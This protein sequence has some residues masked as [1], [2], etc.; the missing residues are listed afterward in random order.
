[1]SAAEP[2]RPDTVDAFLKAFRASGLDPRAFCPAYGL[3][4]HTVG[5]TV[6]GQRLA[7]VDRDALGTQR[8]A[9]ALLAD[10]ALPVV[11]TRTDDDDARPPTPDAPTATAAPDLLAAL[12]RVVSS[13][14]RLSLG[15]DDDLQRH[16][17][18]DSLQ[19][20]E[21]GMALERVAGRGVSAATLQ[22]C[23]TLRALAR[24]LSGAAPSTRLAL[25]AGPPEPVP[26]LLAPPLFLRARDLGA[27]AATLGRTRRIYAL[28]PVG[29]RFD[30]V[31]DA[32]LEGALERLEG[33]RRCVLVGRRSAASWRTRW[34]RGSPRAAWRCPGW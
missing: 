27:L 13:F 20:V 24:H 6:R 3:A 7:H 8:A 1:M 15:P 30:E 25:L 34:P 9:R 11:Y 5:V 28:E 2:V 16:L 21:L 29:E 23:A 22:R 12:T 32:L 18:L 10:G 33:A 19:A 31:I 26:A 14:A 17:H 4:E